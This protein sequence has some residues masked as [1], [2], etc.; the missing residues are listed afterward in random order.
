LLYDNGFFEEGYSLA[1][2]LL[3][4]Q[5]DLWYI[6]LD[7]NKRAEQYLDF[8]KLKSN[9]QV[10]MLNNLNPSLTPPAKFSIKNKFKNKTRWAQLTFEGML[11]TIFQD[12]TQTIDS[13]LISYKYLCGFS[14]P[15]ASGLGSNTVFSK[16]DIPVW[17][18]YNE[19]LK[20][21][22]PLLSCQLTLAVYHLVDKSFSLGCSAQIK[23][24]NDEVSRLA[25]NN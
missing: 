23:K 5:V 21:V 4:T 24:I 22:L 15:S 9:E 13:L 7:E 25:T 1:R 14:H 8:D 2:I 6:G 20:R 11:K 16:K 3:E 18:K 12:D 17:E 10:D 19:N